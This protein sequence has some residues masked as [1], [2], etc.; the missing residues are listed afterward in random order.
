MQNTDDIM[1]LKLSEHLNFSR[2]FLQQKFTFNHFFSLNRKYSKANKIR[3]TYMAASRNL[4]LGRI[5]ASLYAF[6]NQNWKKTL[7]LTI[8]HCFDFVL[9][10]KLNVYLFASN[11]E[12][13]QEG[14]RRIT[15]K[16]TNFKLLKRFKQSR[17]YIFS[18]YCQ[19]LNSG[20]VVLSQLHSPHYQ[21][22]L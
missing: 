5:V 9:C 4:I 22:Q 12:A 16:L 3:Q 10:T 15:L 21:H 2:I 20:P 18:I 6:F 19:I 17:F 1:I 7:S 14:T 13:T 8:K 11:Q